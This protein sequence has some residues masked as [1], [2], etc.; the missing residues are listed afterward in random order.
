MAN[1]EKVE[2]ELKKGALEIIGSKYSGPDFY[3]NGKMI[4]SAYGVALEEFDDYMS[5]RHDTHVLAPS[6]LELL[7]HWVEEKTVVRDGEELY[8][9][10]QFEAYLLNAMIDKKMKE[11]EKEKQ[12]LLGNFGKEIEQIPLEPAKC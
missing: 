10:T 7:K 8:I 4:L 1:L 2:E 6:G 9:M 12:S 5:R 3:S 11:L